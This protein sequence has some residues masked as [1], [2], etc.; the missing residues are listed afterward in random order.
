[1]ESNLQTELQIPHEMQIPIILLATT[2]NLRCKQIQVN[3]D[4]STKIQTMGSVLNKDLFGHG[5][6]DDNDDHD[7]DVPT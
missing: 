3:V 5:N 1:M 2:S 6:V 4:G 7:E